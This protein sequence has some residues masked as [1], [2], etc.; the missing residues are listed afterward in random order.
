MTEERDKENICLCGSLGVAVDDL[1]NCEIH[2]RGHTILGCQVCG[3]GLCKLFF[4]FKEP[5]E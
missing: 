1:L 2:L 4:E 5:K 3:G